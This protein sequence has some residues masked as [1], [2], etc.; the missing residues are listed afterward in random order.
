MVACDLRT[1]LFSW[2]QDAAHS[3]DARAEAVGYMYVLRDTCQLFG[4]TIVNIR[5]RISY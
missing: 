3:P 2:L 4:A 1:Q 5:S